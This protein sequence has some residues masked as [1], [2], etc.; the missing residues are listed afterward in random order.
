MALWVWADDSILFSELLV[1]AA[2]AAMGAT[3]VEIVQNQTASHVRIRAEWLGAA[4]RLPPRVLRDTITVYGAIARTIRT[5][6]PPASRFEEVPVHARGETAADVTHRALIVG[7]A[8][9]AP[10]T[11]VLGIDTE[12]DVMVVHHLVP[13]KRARGA[14][15]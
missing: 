1:G 15:S 5:G 2:V 7:G 10:N 4:V 9:L 3:L 12:R 13:P 11:F 8:S 14:A 6:R